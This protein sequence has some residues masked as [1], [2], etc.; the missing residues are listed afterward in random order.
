MMAR[1]DMQVSSH[2]ELCLCETLK[3]MQQDSLSK[4]DMLEVSR[5]LQAM[6]VSQSHLKAANHC[7][8]F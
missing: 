6:A 5:Y 8:L 4:E 1:S 2:S 3:T 7:A